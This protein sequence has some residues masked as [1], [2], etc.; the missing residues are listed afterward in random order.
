MS[1]I[2]GIEV[3]EAGRCCHY[4]QANDI[5]GLKC[6]QCQQ[7]FACYKCHDTLRDHRFVPCAKHAA[8]AICGVCKFTMDFQKYVQGFCPNCQHSFN[9][10]CR[11]HYGIYFK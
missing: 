5:V 6:A 10:K 2:H 9:P 4:H 3:D 8:P 1:I 11:V 7:Y